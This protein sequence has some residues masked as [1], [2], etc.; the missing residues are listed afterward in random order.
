MPSFGECSLL[1]RL[2]IA[3]PKVSASEVVTS[4]YHIAA[5]LVAATAAA[6]A[7]VAVA[8]AVADADAAGCHSHSTLL[9]RGVPIPSQRKM[10][11]KAVNSCHL[12][13][14]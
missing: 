1:L 2:T 3:N 7:A 8:V 14:L 12:L 6:S 13:L 4:Q 10:Y 5:A 11:R 9:T